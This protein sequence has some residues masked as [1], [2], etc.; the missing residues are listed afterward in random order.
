[1]YDVLACKDII[2]QCIVSGCWEIWI[3]SLLSHIAGIIKNCRLFS[4]MIN[5]FLGYEVLPVKDLGL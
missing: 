5:V 4:N 2:N 1:M 3:K